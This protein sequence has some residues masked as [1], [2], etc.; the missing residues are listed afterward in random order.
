MPQVIP[1][2]SPSPQQSRDE[3]FY[4][5]ALAITHEVLGGLGAFSAVLGYLATDAQPLKIMFLG[6][7]VIFLSGLCMHARRLRHFSM[8]VGDALCLMF[9]LGTILGIHTLRLLSRESIAVL[10]NPKTR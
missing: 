6:S 10:Y 4:L 2:A 7:L 9:P 1:Y 5:K 8:I 3:I